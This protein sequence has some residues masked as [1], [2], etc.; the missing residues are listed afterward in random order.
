MERSPKIADPLSLVRRLFTAGLYIISAHGKTRQGERQ[1]TLGDIKRVIFKG[2]HE[3]RK[4]EYKK[5]FND[6]NYAFRGKTLDNDEAR[7]C[8]A[9]DQ[10]LAAVLVTV[11]RLERKI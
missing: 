3:P 4:D 9:F 2:R 5:E 10:E 11:I 1:L 7:I 8:V 6:W